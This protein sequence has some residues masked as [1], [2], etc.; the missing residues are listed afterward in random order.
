MDPHRAFRLGREEGILALQKG[1]APG[2]IYQVHH[3]FILIA[4]TLS[5]TRALSFLDPMRLTSGLGWKTDHHSAVGM[6]H[7]VLLLADASRNFARN[8]YSH[9]LRYSDCTSDG[10]DCHYSNRSNRSGDCSAAV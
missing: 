4:S 2:M 7:G 6:S 8:S 5:C 10:R 1:L 9:C 3:V